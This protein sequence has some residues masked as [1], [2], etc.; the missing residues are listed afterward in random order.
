MKWMH[1]AEPDSTDNH[2]AYSLYSQ[3]NTISQVKLISSILWF[4]II[5]NVNG[6]EPVRG[7]NSILQRRINSK[8]R[9][10]SRSESL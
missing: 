3:E 10:I 1:V 9:R 2:P 7:Y 6:S 4:F 5:M 8:P